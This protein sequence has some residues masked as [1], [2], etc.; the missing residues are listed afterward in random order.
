M[1][2]ENHFL[3]YQK[4]RQE[5]KAYNEVL[6]EKPE[7]IFLSKSDIVAKEKIA[8]IVDDFKKQNKEIIPISIIDLASLE[9]IKKLLN[10]IAKEKQTPL[11]I[12]NIVDN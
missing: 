7:Y 9:K 8:E 6:L 12:E 3:D 1:D 4:V 11:F 2:I 10:Q 5:L